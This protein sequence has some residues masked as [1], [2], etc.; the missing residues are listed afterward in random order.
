MLRQLCGEK[1]FDL[2]GSSVLIKYETKSFSSRQKI[3][4]YGV[5]VYL[6][7]GASYL[8]TLAINCNELLTED[9]L[10]SVALGILAQCR[11][12]I[13]M[14]T[15]AVV[16]KPRIEFVDLCETDI[17]KVTDRYYPW[18]KFVVRKFT[19]VL[20]LPKFEPVKDLASRIYHTLERNGCLLPL[21]TKTEKLGLRLEYRED[22]R[23]FV[24]ILE[25]GQSL[26]FQ[27]GKVGAELTDQKMKPGVKLETFLES[28]ARYVSPRSKRTDVE[29]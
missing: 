15:V 14:S 2:G 4:R 6:E 19:D 25:P 8:T 23:R 21:V 9:H 7:G 3:L 17:K 28:V 27:I 29:K 11:E 18:Q 12:G 13:A 20:G 10:K 1:R 22:D 16:K 5:A 26:T 24:L